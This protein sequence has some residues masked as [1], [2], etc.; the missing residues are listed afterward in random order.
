MIGATRAL[1]SAPRHLRRFGTPPVVSPAVLGLCALLVGLAYPIAAYRVHPLA[2]PAAAIMAGLAVVS[3]SRPE[4]GVAVAFV[5]LSLN[6]GLIGGRPWLPGT[7][8]TVFLFVAAVTGRTERGD[9]SSALGV[10]ALTFGILGLAGVV[11]SGDPGDATPVLR[12]VF[13]GLALFYVIST[14]VRT[15]EQVHWV[16]GGIVAGA[17]LIGGYATLQYLRGT[18]SSV[19]FITDTGELVTRVTAG[20]GQPNQ[21]AGFLLLV[22]G[23]AIGG[24]LLPAPGR[25]LY[26]AAAAVSLVGI[27]GSFSR[28][29]QL[30]LVVLPLVFLGGRRA[31]LLA[32]VVLLTFVAAAPDLARERF[33]TLTQEGGE[34]ADRVDFWRTAGSLWADNPI[35]GVG[36]GGFDE[37]YAEARVP[38]KRF[39]PDTS[40]EPPPHAHNLALNLLAEQGVVGFAGFAVVFWLACRDS[41]RLRRSPERWIRV[42]A[43]ALVASLLGF[44]IHNQFDVTLGEGTGTYFWGVLGLVAAVRSVPRQEGSRVFPR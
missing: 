11:V 25:T 32:P 22:V 20:F 3:L 27:Y 44:A 40:F 31:L 43:S 23:L 29:A 18:G 1:S 41:V 6:S 12:S 8:W 10:A 30:G 34:V 35:F 38:G 28:G 16:L 21:L 13:T 7:A 24:I 5:L 36:P 39:L 19:G 33:G 37:A 17:A 15:R 14:R 42:L 2:L 26:G 4:I 9:G